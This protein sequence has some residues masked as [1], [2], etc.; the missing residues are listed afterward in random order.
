MY[1]KEVQFRIKQKIPDWNSENL[2]LKVY[3]FYL[4]VVVPFSLKQLQY[5]RFDV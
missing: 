2:I 5:F 3:T 1:W 4:K